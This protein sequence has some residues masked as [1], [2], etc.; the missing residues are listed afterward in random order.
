MERHLRGGTDHQTIIFIPVGHADVRLDVRLLDLRY[1][2]FRFEDLIG[3]GESFFHVADVDA[4]V[5]G[6]ILFGVRVREVDELR[7]IVDAWRA[8]LHRLP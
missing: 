4:D 3:F 1:L 5:G 8:F 7:L 2:V 6:E